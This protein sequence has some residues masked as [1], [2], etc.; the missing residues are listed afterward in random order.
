MAVINIRIEDDGHSVKVTSD[1][2]F[3]TMAMMINSGHAS[4]AAHGYAL[5]CI[6][7]ITKVSKEMGSKNKILLPRIGKA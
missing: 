2:T 3:E 4:T 6:N 7:H 1:P 5:A